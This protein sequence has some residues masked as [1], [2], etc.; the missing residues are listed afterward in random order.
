MSLMDK[1]RHY[2]KEIIKDSIAWELEIEQGDDI[3]MINGKEIQDVFDYHYLINDEKIILSIRKPDGTVWEADIEKGYDEDLG[4]IFD[5]NLMDDYRSCRNKCIFCFIDQMPPGMRETLYFKDDDAR[6]SF[7]MGNYITLTNMTKED[8]DRI[9]FYKLSPINISIHTADIELRKRMLNNRFAGEA[10][11]YLKKFYD[12]HIYMNAQIVL[13]KGYNDKDDLRKT[14]EFLSKYLPYMQSVSV[15]PAG[16]TKYREGLAVIEPFTRDE[17]AEVISVIEEYQN[18]I[19]KKHGTRMIHASDEWYIKALADFPPAKN[20]EGYMQFENGVGMVRSL[21]D[22]FDEYFELQKGDNRI[23]NVSAATGVLFAPILKQIAVKIK[24]KYPNVH[25][26]VYT[27]FNYYFGTDITVA[28]LLTGQDIINQLKGKKLY[29][30]LLLPSSLLK[31]DDD[32]LLDDVRISD[33]EKALQTRISI[34]QSKG[35]SLLELILNAES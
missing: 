7:L 10:L 32:I 5:D 27:I 20:Y 29:D 8:I 24:E 21:L 25:V 14:I 12:A 26:E 11:K 30:C 33:I 15:V 22:E 18:I 2:V 34:V 19:Y 3:Y 35:S 28:G 6:L 1:K 9:C 16:L 17:A 31:A 23:R 13:C 4:I